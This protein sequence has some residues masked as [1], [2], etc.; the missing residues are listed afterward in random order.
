MVEMNVARRRTAAIFLCF[1]FIS[2]SAASAGRAEE[3][4]VPAVRT[5][6]AAEKPLQ[7]GVSSMPDERKIWT[8]DRVERSFAGEDPIEEYNRCVFAF[9]DFLFMYIARPIGWVYCSILPKPVI[10]CL[11]NFCENLR[12]PARAISALCRAEWRG[13]GDETVRFLANSTIGIA[14]LFD[15]AKHWFYSH[16]PYSTFGQAFAAWGLDSGCT[17]MLPFMYQ[18]VNVRDTVGAI[19]D[20]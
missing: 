18:Y 15:P 16:P 4:T 6:N 9:N 3:K 17:F 7:N 12:F 19:F 5:E 20:K 2:L 13:A 1:L 10:T 14:G 11:D 8:V